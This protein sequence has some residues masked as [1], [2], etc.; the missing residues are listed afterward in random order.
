VREDGGNGIE[1]VLG[2]ELAVGDAARPEGFEAEGVAVLEPVGDL[3]D[4]GGFEV[5]R[6]W[7]LARAGCGAGENV[8]ASRDK[9]KG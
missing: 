2:G 1:E 7:G 3:L 6:E 8:A 4:A 9:S 5:V